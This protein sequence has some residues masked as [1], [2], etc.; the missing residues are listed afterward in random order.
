MSTFLSTAHK[1]RAKGDIE[2]YAIALS[3]VYGY[4]SDED[5]EFVRLYSHHFIP[6]SNVVG[7]RR[8]ERAEGA[9]R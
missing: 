6:N 8:G 2:G 7:L 3:K 9:K 5:E 4:A 1:L